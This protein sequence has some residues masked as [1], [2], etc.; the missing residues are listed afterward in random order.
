MPTGPSALDLLSRGTIEVKG[1]MPGA[2]NVTLLVECALGEDAALAIYKPRRGERRL[3]DF[4]PGLWKRE[5]AAYVL[6]EALGWGLVPLT[7]PRDGPHGE[8]SL[9]L[10]IHA[11]F[12]QHYFSLVEDAAHHD[13]LRRICLFD[14]VTNN[15]DRKSGHCLLVPDDRIYA[16]DN[17]LTFHAEPKLRTVIW[18]FGEEPIAPRCRRICAACW[19]TICRPPSPSCSIPTSS[20]RSSA[21]RADSPRGAVSGG[22]ERHALPLA[23]DLIVPLPSGERAG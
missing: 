5:L 18:D 22:H 14:L 7:V 21:A 4:P 19:P 3:W 6:S 9:Q 1:R 20:A 2:S 17:G 8:G 23:A 15:A 16:I 12:E 11:D 13:T 10:F